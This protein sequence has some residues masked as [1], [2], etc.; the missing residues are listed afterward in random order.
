MM[1]FQMFH[2]YVNHYQ[3]VFWLFRWLSH[4][5][6]PH[7]LRI[8]SGRECSAAIC[9]RSSLFFSASRASRSHKTSIKNDKHLSDLENSLNGYEWLFFRKKVYDT[10]VP[11]GGSLVH[12]L[13]FAIL[14]DLRHRIL[15]DP[16]SLHCS[17]LVCSKYVQSLNLS[18]SCEISEGKR[19]FKTCLFLYIST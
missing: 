8:L 7:R 14:S 16:L 6:F 11:N 2:S 3:R 13:T 1:I 9:R 12:L 4:L 10:W 5:A 17:R 18:Q 15:W 19:C